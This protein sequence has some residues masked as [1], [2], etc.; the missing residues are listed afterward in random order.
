MCIKVFFKTPD[1][2]L[3]RKNEKMY[4]FNIIILNFFNFENIKLALRSE[5]IKIIHLNRA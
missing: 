4:Y 3:S 1:K 5:L 2:E